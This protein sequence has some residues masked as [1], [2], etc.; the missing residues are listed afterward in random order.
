MNNFQML[1]IGLVPGAIAAT[2]MMPFYSRLSSMRDW[3]TW[4][5]ITGFWPYLALWGLPKLLHWYIKQWWK[6]SDLRRSRRLR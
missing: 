3:Q 1:L 5:F 4:L 2:A 6:Y